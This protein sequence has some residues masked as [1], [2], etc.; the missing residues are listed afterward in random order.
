MKLAVM[1]G[2]SVLAL[3]R[4]TK[5]PKCEKTCPTYEGLMRRGSLNCKIRKHC[6]RK[7]PLH[8]TLHPY[9]F[10][11]CVSQKYYD[12][13]KE[14]YTKL[15]VKCNG[16]AGKWASCG[17]KLKKCT[18]YEKYNWGSCKCERKNYCKE[19]CP[20]GKALHPSYA[21]K[22]VDILNDEIP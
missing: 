6:K 21:C 16:P 12:K 15:L 2:I 4:D 11:K 14:D 7:C 8:S 20:A 10:C 18:F 3:G 13:S 17:K 1:L 5:D 19:G 22:C 9:K